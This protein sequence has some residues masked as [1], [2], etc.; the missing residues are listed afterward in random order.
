[1][2]HESGTYRV[3]REHGTL[4][5]KFHERWVHFLIKIFNYLVF[6]II[7]HILIK[8][9]TLYDSLSVITLKEYWCMTAIVHYYKTYRKKEAQSK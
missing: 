4:T 6:L 1:M 9:L 8:I 3:V 5:L 2:L 7:S